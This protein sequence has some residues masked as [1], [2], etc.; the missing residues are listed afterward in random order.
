MLLAAAAVA[1]GA[2]VQSA[3]GFGFGLVLSPAL[4]AAFEPY[5]AVSVLLVLSLAL[6]LLVLADGG[7]GPVRWRIL[8]PLMAAAVPGMGV[9]VLVLKSVSKPVL[10]IALGLAVMA[11][12]AWQL[13]SLT[14]RGSVPAAGA[15]SEPPL[16]G[17]FTAGFVSGTLTTSIVVSG[18]PILLWLEAVGL[19][20]AEVRATLA[21]SF[22]VL[23]LAGGGIVIAAGGAG[24]LRASVLV[25]MLGLVLAGHLAGA[26]AFRRL[27]GSHF[28]HLV[29]GLAACAGTASLVAGLAGL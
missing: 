26:L 19:R 6:N 1:I 14:A 17:G 4:F 25:P 8:A 15:R 5:E 23:N 18:P 27:A 9:G 16:A 22:L 21:A 3:T 7:P 28:S 24:T 29:L 20:P 12:T 2:A 11:A 10:Q 13:R